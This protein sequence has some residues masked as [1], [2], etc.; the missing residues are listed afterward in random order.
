MSR[1]GDIPASSSS[2]DTTSARWRDYFSPVS[3]HLFCPYL[4]LNHSL[5]N[6]TS[7]R[8]KFLNALLSHRFPLTILWLA[9]WNELRL[10]LESDEKPLMEH[11]WLSG[12]EFPTNRIA[13]NRWPD[14]RAQPSTKAALG[15]LVHVCSGCER[16]TS[17]RF[18]PT[19][20]PTAAQP[21]RG[22]F[23]SGLPALASQA[24][25]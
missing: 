12:A 21:Y 13:E 16:G 19:W 11:L 25:A 23:V 1:K 17:L 6:V 2:H 8:N 22:S 9:I 10:C 24:S 15:L 14:C 5:G 7:S 18:I 4:I 20:F 3:F